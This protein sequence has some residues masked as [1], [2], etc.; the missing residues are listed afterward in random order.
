VDGFSWELKPEVLVSLGLKASAMGRRAVPPF[1]YALVFALQQRKSTENPVRAAEQLEDYSLR[2]LGCL[3]R[4]WTSIYLGY[5]G[6]LSQP[7]VG[8]NAWQLTGLRASPPTIFES[9]LSVSAL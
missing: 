7:S 8:T 1:N 5:Q 2:R 9:K 6:E 3:L 4:G